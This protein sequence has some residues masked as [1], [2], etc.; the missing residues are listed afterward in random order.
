MLIPNGERSIEWRLGLSIE[1]PNDYSIRVFQK[2]WQRSYNLLT[3][4]LTSKQ[5][6]KME[7]ISGF[8]VAIEPLEN[9][10]LSRG[11]VVASILLIPNNTFNHEHRVVDIY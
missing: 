4:I 10:K 9:F 5:L 3:G 2:Q 8:S 1:I 6:K 11:D 7:D